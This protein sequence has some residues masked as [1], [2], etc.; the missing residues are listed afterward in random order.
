V[1]SREI[2]AGLWFWSVAHPDWD[3]G[4][5][6]PEQVGQACYVTD[7]A[8]VLF[9]PLVPPGNAAAFWNFVDRRRGDAGL[10]VRVLLTAPWHQRSAEA[11][12]VRYGATV[13][14]HPAGYPRLAVSAVNDAL[15]EGVESFV[16]GGVDEGEVAFY[17]S[18]ARTLF[19]A[20]FLAGVDGGL[21]LVPSPAIHDQGAFLASLDHLLA[22]PIERVIVAHGDSIFENG[23]TRI[24]QALDAHPRG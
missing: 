22:K 7:H 17:I 11:V 2:A 19:V 13:W 5:D 24:E 20:E 14:A 6:W 10:P 8:V 4:D 21:V 3:S 15:P 18:A 23:T 9:D 12:S 1:D 16:L